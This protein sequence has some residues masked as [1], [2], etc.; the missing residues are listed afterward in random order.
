MIEVT[1]HSLEGQILISLNLVPYDNLKKY[2]T[3]AKPNSL[4]L[5]KSIRQINDKTIL[6]SS[7]YP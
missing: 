2:K 1:S 7:E 3:K 6:S 5:S 4:I